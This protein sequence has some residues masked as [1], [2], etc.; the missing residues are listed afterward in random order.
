M[1]KRR[2]LRHDYALNGLVAGYLPL[3]TH[4]GRCHIR[5][6]SPALCFFVAMAL[7]FDF[8]HARL[9]QSS[10]EAAM[11]ALFPSTSFVGGSACLDSVDLVMTDVASL[12]P[13][14]QQYWASV[15]VPHLVLLGNAPHPVTPA[16]WS[17]AGMT[18]A[19][20][21]MGGETDG[22]HSILLLLPRSMPAPDGPPPTPPSLP[23]APL[24][25]SLNPVQPASRAAVPSD[26]GGLRAEVSYT[27]NGKEVLPHGLFPTGR[28]D[29]RVWVPCVFNKP[30]F[31]G[32]RPLSPRAGRS[33]G[34][35]FVLAGV[36]V[37]P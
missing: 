13:S 20:C 2:V 12:P 30:T 8:V 35:T 34:R 10:F 19:H 7:G 22:V 21:D 9:P 31:W 3:R 5:L 17:S 37:T 36:G 23:W 29:M 14:S 24:R 26:P 6:G 25:G 32:S 28:T 33:L 15:D 18:L 4:R 27:A 11:R 16:G 1:G